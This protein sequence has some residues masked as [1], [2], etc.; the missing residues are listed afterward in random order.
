MTK[1]KF[2]DK[3]PFFMKNDP[4]VPQANYLFLGVLAV[5]ITLK[6]LGKLF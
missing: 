1:E 6:I 4:A 5:A 2:T 3:Q